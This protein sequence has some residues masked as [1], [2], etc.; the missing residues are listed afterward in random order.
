MKP[1]ITIE[2]LQAVYNSGL[3][4]YVLHGVNDGL[5]DSLDNTPA[6]QTAAEILALLPEINMDESNRKETEEHLY[7][8]I[9]CVTINAESL[10]EL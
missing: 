1:I 4:W 7:C 2:I 8:I 9:N 5:S 6:K 10:L 3:L